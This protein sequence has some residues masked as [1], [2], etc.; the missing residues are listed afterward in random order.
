MQVRGCRLVNLSVL[1]PSDSCRNLMNFSI[2]QLILT[3]RW[4]QNDF[5]NITYVPNNMLI[6]IRKNP[7]AAVCLQWPI[8]CIKIST[9][10]LRCLIWMNLPLVCTS[11]HTCAPHT[12]NQSTTQ[13]DKANS[14]V[15][16]HWYAT[17]TGFLWIQVVIAKPQCTLPFRSPI[18]A[19]SNHISSY[20]NFT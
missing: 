12:L 16:N 3:C 1:Q 17:R 5:I 6:L 7:L 13:T 20:L 8:V 2:E 4:I 14:K 15:R 11:P 19:I 18:T 10:C 9:P